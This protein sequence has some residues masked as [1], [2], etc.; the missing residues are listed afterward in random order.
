MALKKIIIKY[1]DALLSNW[2]S[3]LCE[4]QG[5]RGN[6]REK[7]ERKVQVLARTF[8]MIVMARYR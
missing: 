8:F 6:R 5:E 7:K 3:T 2:W 1:S 4:P